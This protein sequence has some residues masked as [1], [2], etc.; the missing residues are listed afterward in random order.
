LRLI[1]DY[2]PAGAQ[3]YRLLPDTMYDL[4]LYRYDPAR[5]PRAPRP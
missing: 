1:D 4:V 5:R 2:S 3:Q